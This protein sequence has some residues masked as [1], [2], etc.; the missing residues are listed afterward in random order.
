MNGITIYRELG[1]PSPDLVRW[2]DARNQ[3]FEVDDPKGNS[4]LYID[5]SIPRD[6]DITEEIVGRL[7]AKHGD[8]TFPGLQ[9]CTIGFALFRDEPDENGDYFIAS[10]NSLDKAEQ[11]KASARIVVSADISGVETGWSSLESDDI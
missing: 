11:A 7:P 3:L 5:D 9:G 6:A 8:M 4:H 10:F 2:L 1:N